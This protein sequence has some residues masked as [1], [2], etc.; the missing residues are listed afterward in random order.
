M[1]NDKA[2]TASAAAHTI[3]RLLPESQP[4][5]HLLTAV[6]RH[7][8]T[9]LAASVEHDHA[10]NVLHD[11]IAALPGPIAVELSNQIEALLEQL[12]R[13]PLC[14]TQKP[15]RPPVSWPTRESGSVN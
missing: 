11:V 5:R 15:N 1:S 2:G 9:A 7:T 10:A 3:V 12:S 14:G 8:A 6:N 13:C 4:A